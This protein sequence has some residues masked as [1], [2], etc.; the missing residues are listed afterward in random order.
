[1]ASASIP[2]TSVLH[3]ALKCS[4]EHSQLATLSVADTPPMI[5]SSYLYMY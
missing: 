5:L 2:N 3:S 1:M 4:A